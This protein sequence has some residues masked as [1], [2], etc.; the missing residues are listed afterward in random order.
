MLT[1][2]ND[3][4]CSN[5]KPQFTSKV[6]FR[7][8][9]TVCQVRLGY[10]RLIRFKIQCHLLLKRTDYEFERSGENSCLSI[11]IRSGTV[12]HYYQ[13]AYPFCRD[14]YRSG[15]D[16]RLESVLATFP[17]RD[18][19]SLPQRQFNPRNLSAQTGQQNYQSKMDF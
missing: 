2:Y 12:G 18:G 7:L 17:D 13:Y 10:C 19:S 5:L 16:R 6:H 9:K 1:F 4:C 8:P 14:T 3:Q 15:C 11:T